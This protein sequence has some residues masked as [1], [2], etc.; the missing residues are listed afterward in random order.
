MIG[1]DFEILLLLGILLHVS[2]LTVPNP[3]EIENTVIKAR[4]ISNHQSA[5]QDEELSS[6]LDSR[7][8]NNDT[9]C[10]SFLQDMR[11]LIYTAQSANR[12]ISFDSNEA[13]RWLAQRTGFS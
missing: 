8:V 13:L 12:Q 1:L 3:L 9:F 11:D 10:D 5:E 2:D 4:D 7:A 6:L